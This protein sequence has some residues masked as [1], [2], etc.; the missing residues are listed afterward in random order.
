MHQKDMGQSINRYKPIRY[1]ES[2]NC[3]TVKSEPVITVNNLFDTLVY[4]AIKYKKMFL[5]SLFEI[6]KVWNCQ[7][8]AF[9]CEVLSGIITTSLHYESFDAVGKSTHRSVD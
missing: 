9:L 3:I 8:T 2:Y 1:Y 4:T 7:L 6:R 5:L